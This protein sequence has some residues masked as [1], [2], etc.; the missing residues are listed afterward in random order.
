MHNERASILQLEDAVKNAMTTI[1]GNVIRV[2]TKSGIRIDKAIAGDIKKRIN[3]RKRKDIGSAEKSIASLQ[4]HYSW[5]TRLNSQ[6]Q[7]EG[8]PAGVRE[9]VS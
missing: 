9:F 7:Q 1:T 3:T 4:Q 2:L 6:I 5:L 8:V